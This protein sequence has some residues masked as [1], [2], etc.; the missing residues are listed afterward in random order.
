VISGEPDGLNGPA[1]LRAV[2]GKWAA[3][4]GSVDLDRANAVYTHERI[5]RTWPHQEANAWV[6]QSAS[7]ASPVC[8]IWTSPE[9]SALTIAISDRFPSS[10]VRVKTI[11]VPSGDH[12]G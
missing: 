12:P 5:F 9:P 6:P 10:V 4:D 11:F 1:I 8:V 3:P 7:P 2:S